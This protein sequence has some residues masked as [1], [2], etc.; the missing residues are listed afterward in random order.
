MALQTCKH[1][2]D[3]KSF[4]PLGQ[5]K[6]VTVHEYMR[7]SRRQILFKCVGNEQHQ[8]TAIVLCN[9][10]LQVSHTNNAKITKHTTDT[11][12]RNL[13]RESQML[14]QSTP[15]ANSHSNSYIVQTSRLN[16]GHCRPVSSSAF[17]TCASRRRRHLLP[18][19]SSS[20][21]SKADSSCCFLRTKQRRLETFL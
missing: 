10:V 21:S 6:L 17:A 4:S 18:S 1:F 15:T 13:T 5:Q 2:R 12:V 3:W 9:D 7:T 14:E 20:L 19:S 16:I 11:S 8:F